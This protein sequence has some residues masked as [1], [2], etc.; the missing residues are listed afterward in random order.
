[1]Q[2]PE[3]PTLEVVSFVTSEEEQQSQDG[4]S[5]QTPYC[6]TNVWVCDTDLE[7]TA[8]VCSSSDYYGGVSCTDECHPG[9]SGC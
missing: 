2:I 4:T 9:S 3:L 8:T 7:C 5:L 1:M 6:P